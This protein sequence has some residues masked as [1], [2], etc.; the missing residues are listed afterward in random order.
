LPHAPPLSSGVGP[1]GVARFRRPGV[2]VLSVL[3]AEI[4]AGRPAFHAGRNRHDRLDA[5]SFGGSGVD[6][7]RLVIG[8]VHR[9]R[10]P[11]FAGAPEGDDSGGADHAGGLSS[12]LSAFEIGAGRYLP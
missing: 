6:L 11:R 5:L 9:P 10:Y 7:R 4:P 1:A 12:R 8:T 2:V 3:A